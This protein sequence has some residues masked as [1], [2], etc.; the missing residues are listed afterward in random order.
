VMTRIF[1]IFVRK[2]KYVEPST[3]IAS[4][5]LNMRRPTVDEN[6]STFLTHTN[7][8][9]A[10]NMANNSATGVLVVHGAASSMISG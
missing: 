8:P 10:H 6:F 1:P 2:V 4:Y 5:P 9:G 7:A 3:I